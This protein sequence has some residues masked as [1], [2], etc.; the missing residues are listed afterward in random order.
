MDLNYD[1]A[2][3]GGGP[4]G[5][6]AA[7]AARKFGARVLLIEK[8]GFVGGMSTAGLLNVWCG[9]ASSAFYE[10]IR[11]KTTEKRVRRYV[12]S[13]EILKNLYLEELEMAG[14]EILLHALVTDA[15]VEDGII[16]TLILQSKIQKIRLSAKIFIDSTGDGDVA[17]LA[18]VPYKIG[19]PS[20]GLT[21]PMSLEFVVGGVDDSRAVY[22]TFGTHPE[23]EEKMRR[24]VK[25]GRIL[26]PAGHVILL[27]GYYP[28]TAHVNMTNVT[29]VIGTD[30]LDRTRAEI[31]ARKQIP[32]IVQFLRECVPGYENCFVIASGCYAGVR[33]S[34][35]FEGEY[36]LT[37]HDI[38]AQKIFPDWIVS[39][40]SSS[41]NNHSLSGSGPDA[42]NLVY[43]GERYTIPYRSFLPKAV[44]NLLLNG[45]NISGNHMSHSSFRVMPI[46][47]AMG[48]GVG[49]AAA[50]AIKKQTDLC[51]VDTK[52]VQRILIEEYG[53]TPPSPRKI[54]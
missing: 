25:D 49:T 44:R 12:F 22:P 53:I 27:E 37:E 4:S 9:S 34:R 3:I 54:D 45:R 42:S 31:H 48:E 29:H 13:P 43:K 1:I 35:H 39:N 52:E 2:V 15:E 28:T 18:G 46:C 23:L 10:R 5:L 21:Q 19:R 24:Y 17:A 14:V 36:I 32:Q 41:F 6:A 40:A 50:L 11:S 7:I 33:E 8:E 51:N 30:C 47:F 16:K 38:I 26:P 20:D